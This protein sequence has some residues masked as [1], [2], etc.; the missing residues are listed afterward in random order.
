MRGSTVAAVI[1]T[2]LGLLTCLHGLFGS[3]SDA[4]HAADFG[5]AAMLLALAA[6]L[7]TVEHDRGDK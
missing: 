5:R 4:R 3:P 2:L 7:R 1:G 6:Y